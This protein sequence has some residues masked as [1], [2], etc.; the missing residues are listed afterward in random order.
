MNVFEWMSATYITR[1]ELS[2]PNNIEY[3]EHSILFGINYNNMNELKWAHQKKP[4]L[5]CKDGFNM[6]VQGGAGIYSEPRM[7]SEFYTSME[8]GFP[9]QGEPEFDNSDSV[10]GYLTIDKIEN[11]VNRHGGIDIYNSLKG[12][13]NNNAQKWFRK[14]KLER[15]LK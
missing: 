3:D 12:L 7:P 6:S 14:I 2:L 10:T 5:Y 1:K 13:T 8:I 15:V 9:S 4:R 11:V